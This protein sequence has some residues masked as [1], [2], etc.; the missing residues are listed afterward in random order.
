[1]MVLKNG[2]AISYFCI[3]VIGFNLKTCVISY[4]ASIVT[5]CFIAGFFKALA[6]GKSI[7][8]VD[9]HVLWS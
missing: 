5:M 4:G 2:N 3:F 1:M 6:A 9:R 8:N 7:N